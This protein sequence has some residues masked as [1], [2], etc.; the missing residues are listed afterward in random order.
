MTIS[1][2]ITTIDW[3]KR[4]FRKDAAKW[5]RICLAVPCLMASLCFGMVGCGGG[6]DDA[7]DD[8]TTTDDAGDET[9]TEEPGSDTE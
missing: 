5:V 9:G 6:A 3:E 4:M 8:A 7:T 2:E 1:Q